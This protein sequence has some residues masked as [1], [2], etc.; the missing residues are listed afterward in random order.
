[1]TMDERIE[2]AAWQPIETA[3]KDGQKIKLLIPYNRTLFSEKECTD[4]GFWEPLVE[5]GTVASIGLGIPQW[6]VDQGGC[7][8]FDGDDG[9]FDIQPTHWMPLPDP[10]ATE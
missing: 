3:P 10:P 9:S 7:W 1:M 5:Q 4:K 2:A 6:G 8:R